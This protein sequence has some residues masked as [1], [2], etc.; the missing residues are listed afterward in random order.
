MDK[1]NAG[2][3]RVGRHR[4]SAAAESRRAVPQK[5]QHRNN[6][7]PSNFGPRWIQQGTGDSTPTHMGIGM[8]TAAPSTAAESDHHTGVHQQRNGRQSGVRPYNK[9]LLGHNRKGILTH[10]RVWMN[11]ENIM[12]SERSQRE[13]ATYL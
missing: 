6:M 8:L 10:A 3:L 11:Q 2:P 5:L 13:R 9:T 1:P 12:L 4:D 7:E